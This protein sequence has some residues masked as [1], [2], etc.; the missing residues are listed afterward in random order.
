MRAQHNGAAYHSDEQ[1]GYEICCSRQ[2][3]HRTRKRKAVELKS[4]SL[5]GC[6][7]P[8]ADYN[9]I[10]SPIVVRFAF[11]LKRPH[12]WIPIWMCHRPKAGKIYFNTSWVMLTGQLPTT[13]PYR[14]SY[15]R[16]HNVCRS[17]EWNLFTSEPDTHPPSKNLSPS[18]L[19]R[20]GSPIRQLKMIK[21][22]PVEH[23]SQ[24]T[25]LIARVLTEVTDQ[26][27]IAKV[28]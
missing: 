15:N 18:S 16:R 13:S 5:P 7:F 19:A 24:E 2:A 22:S 4:R 6:N 25:H 12:N 20:I 1:D 21:K 26:K 11:S 23:L 10:A 3:P 8:A 28:N 9:P 17:V 14:T 27:L